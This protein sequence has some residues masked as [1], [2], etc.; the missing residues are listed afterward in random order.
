MNPPLG[1]GLVGA[2][3][4]ADFHVRAIAELDGARLTAVAGRDPGRTAAFARRHGIGF[5][6]TRVDELCARP[7]VQIVDIVTPSGAHLDAGLA[8]CR[9]GKAIVVEKPIE[10][11]LERV[12]RMLGA[13]E[14]AGVP[15]AAIF[16]A[17]FGPGAQALKRAVAAGRFGRLALA[18][19]YVK[20]FRPPEYYRGG[21]HG[22]RALDGGGALMNQAIHAVDL[23]IWLAGMPAEVVGR[24]ARRVHTGIEVED[25]AVAGLRFADGALGTIEATTAAFPGWARRLEIAGES[26]SAVLE[27]DR[28]IR[29][30]FREPQPDDEAVRR[31]AT[32]E[33][34]GSGAGGANQISHHGHRRQ[35]QD[36]V[37]ALRMNRTP[38]VDGR[39]AR[40]AVALIGAIYAA[41]ESGGPVRLAPS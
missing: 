10:I 24:T 6:T 19:A 34:P 23:L 29:W 2:G 8:A 15:V 35:L 39:E 18:S 9:A 3:L 4:I 17:R 13:A 30:E 26:G 33:Q 31:G 1:F 22:T 37:D 16:Q 25:T 27:D 11:T 40:K 28:L 32:D 14:T 7:D 5:W 41:A 21:W 12:D 20:W 36:F 38:A